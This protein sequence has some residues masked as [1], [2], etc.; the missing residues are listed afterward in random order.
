MK[1]S[2]AARC[3]SRQSASFPRSSSALLRPRLG[4]RAAAS[5]TA[6]PVR[7]T[8]LHRPEPSPVARLR[9][10]PRSIVAT[11]PARHSTGRPRAVVSPTWAGSVFVRRASAPVAPWR[12]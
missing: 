6:A 7:P 5:F 2:V 11:R 8:V 1:H 3:T 10:D 12:G 4:L 9:R